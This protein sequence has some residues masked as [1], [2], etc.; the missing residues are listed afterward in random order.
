MAESRFVYVTY[1]R[2]TA[3]SVWD[4]LT[5]PEQNKLFWSGYHQQIVLGGRRRLRDHRPGRPAWDTGKVLAFDPP[6]RLSVTWRHQHDEAMKAE[7]ESTCS[8]ELEAL[9]DGTDQGHRHPRDRRRRLQADRRGLQRLADDP[10]EP[11]EPAGDRQAAGVRRSDQ[12]AARSRARR[13][14]CQA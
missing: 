1:I 2:A 4:A 8:F 3:A 13:P 6:R 11:E 10:V 7:G 5:D 9:S 12:P 14:L